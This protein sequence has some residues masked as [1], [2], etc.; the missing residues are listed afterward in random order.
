MSYYPGPVGARDK[1][2]EMPKV[3]LLDNYDSFVFN[4]VHY[5]AEVGGADLSMEV[6]RNDQ[7]SVDDESLE[8]FSHLVISPGPG[9]PEDTG[10]CHALLRR[11]AP[12]RPILGVCLGHQVIAQHFGCN[13]NYAK[14]IMHGKVCE[15]SH[16]GVSLFEG[17]KSPMRVAR[18]HSLAVERDSI[19]P[20][21]EE[22]AW[23]SDGE[24]MALRHR[25]YQSVIGLQFHPESIA[26]EHGKALLCEFLR[27]ATG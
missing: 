9:R 8:T 12:T 25:V 11:F 20:C 23:T 24:C 4:L 3:L 6:I 7:L 22:I 10:V 2:C 19:P 13:V 14:K 17:L 21:L 16:A 26:T 18:Y 27:Q 15:V 1:Y 5:L